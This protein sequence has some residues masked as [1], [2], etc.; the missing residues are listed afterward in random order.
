MI[1]ISSSHAY[2]PLQKMS[3]NKQKLEKLEISKYF[4]M[5][6]PHATNI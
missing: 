2:R 3:K 4:D 1:D 6:V 5:F